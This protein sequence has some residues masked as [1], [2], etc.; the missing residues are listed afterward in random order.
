MMVNSDYWK[1]PKVLKAE[2]ESDLDIFDH[3]PNHESSVTLQMSD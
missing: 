1:T 2:K 3:L